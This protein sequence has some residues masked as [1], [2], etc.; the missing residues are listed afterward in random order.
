VTRPL[1]V[2]VDSAPPVAL[3]LL[4]P[5][6]TAELPS[7][8]DEVVALLHAEWPDYAAFLAEDTEDILRTAEVALLHLITIAEQVPRGE[9]VASGAVGLAESPLFEEVGRVEWR[10]G[11]SLGTLLSAYRAGAR[12]AWRHLSA[13]AVERGLDPGT[14]ATLAEAVFV[15]VEE[16]SSAS[17]R[18]YVDEQEATTAERQQLRAHLGELLIS[19]RSD[20]TVIRAMALRAGWTLPATVALVLVDPTSQ[21]GEAL[22]GRLPASCLPVRLGELLGAIVPDPDAPGGRALMAQG[23]RGCG[24]VV[25]STVTLDELPSSVRV[26]ESGTRL[27]RAGVLTDDPVFVADHYDTV[28]VAR[29]PWLLDRLREQAL[30]PLADL[31][32]ATRQRLEDTLARLAGRDGRPAGRRPDP[33]DPPAD[34]ALPP[35]PAAGPLR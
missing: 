29:D 11:R 35:A 3:R 16:L 32:P 30:A 14:V 19:D 1:D 34:R 21:A 25:G 10:E 18:G 7:I 31:P 20:S 33:A 13:T 2:P 12:V 15:F 28:M 8:L 17:A 24:A 9:P 4:V 26:A 5:T 27:L 22:L 6:L 23:L